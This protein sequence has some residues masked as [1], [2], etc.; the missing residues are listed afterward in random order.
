MVKVCRYLQ[1]HNSNRILPS[2]KGGVEDKQDLDM[3]PLPWALCSLKCSV[4][5]LW[6]PSRTTCPCRRYSYTFHVT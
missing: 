4:Q 1:I 5:T 3:I 2:G 6:K